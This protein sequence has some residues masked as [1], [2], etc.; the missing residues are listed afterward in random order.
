MGLNSDQLD[1]FFAV[2][3]LASFSRAGEALALS[4]PALSQRVL[5]L[6]EQLAAPVFVREA[7]GVRLTDLGQRLLVYCRSKRDQ[8]AEFL[9]S[10]QGRR[11]GGVIRIAGFSSVMR[12]L[13]MPRLDA[14]L[15]AEPSLQLELSTRELHQLPALLKGGQ[16]DFVVT[17]QPISSAMVESVRL[18]AEENVLIEAAGGKLHAELKDVYYDHDAEDQ[19]TFEFFKLQRQRP[20]AIRRSFTGDVYAIID[21]VERGWGR[22]IIPRHLIA[23]NTKVRVLHGYRPYLLDIYLNSHVLPFYST[24]HQRLLKALKI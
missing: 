14:L 13:I 3:Q 15:K 8:E 19:T 12:S 2:A 11:L 1:A 5:K 18:G 22:A 16:A 9:S 4:Q 6:E 21:A 17:S 20:K 24:L 10:S 23:G 7:S